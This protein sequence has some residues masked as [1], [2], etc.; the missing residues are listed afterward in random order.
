MVF[1]SDVT[2]LSYY[3]NWDE[4]KP[5]VPTIRGGSWFYKSQGRKDLGGVEFWDSARVDQT[6]EDIMLDNQ[7]YYEATTY[8]QVKIKT[9]I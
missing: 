9:R 6:T 3:Q 5:R 1:I 7:P 4:L 2:P 8:H